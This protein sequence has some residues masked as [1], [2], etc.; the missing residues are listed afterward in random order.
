MDFTQTIWN[1]N[2]YQAYIEYLKSL[3][4]DKY[5]EFNSKITPI[6]NE[7]QIYGVRVPKMRD[8]AKL[9]AKGSF[10]AFLDYVDALDNKSLSHEEI[11][12][13]GMVI[14]VNC[15]SLIQFAPISFSADKICNRPCR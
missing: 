7:S 11:S 5:K 10:R 9:I 3:A 6:S 8:T 1:D 12:I 4:D 14:G 15:N 2:S 13:Y